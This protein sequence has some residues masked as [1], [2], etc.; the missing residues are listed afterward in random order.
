MKKIIFFLFIALLGKAQDIIQ[1]NNWQNKGNSWGINN[2]YIGTNDNR[3]FRVRTSGIERFVIDTTATAS[4][5]F[6]T[7]LFI[8]Q[9]A[10][11]NSLSPIKFSFR[12]WTFLNSYPAL[13]FGQHIENTTN[14]FAIADTTLT[15]V[16]GPQ[17]LYLGQGG[18]NGLQI[19]MLENNGNNGTTLAASGHYFFTSGVPSNTVPANLFIPLIVY[20]SLTY[21]L[22]GGIVPTAYL[23]EELAPNIKSTTPTTI[24]EWATQNFPKPIFDDGV[25]VTRMFGVQTNT[26]ISVAGRGIFGLVNTTPTATLDVRGN[27]IISSSLQVNGITNTDGF[28]AAGTGSVGS[29]FTATGAAVLTGGVTTPTVIGTTAAAGTL[30]LWGTNSATMGVISIGQGTAAGLISRGTTTLTGQANLSNT[31]NILGNTTLNT[32]QTNTLTGGNTGTVAVLTDVNLNYE[33]GFSQ[34]NPANNS[35]YGLTTVGQFNVN[36]GTKA[37]IKLPY[38]CTFIGYTYTSYN[39]TT[40]GSSETATLVLCKGGTATTTLSSAVSF[41]QSTATTYFLTDLAQSINYDANEDFSM[42]LKTPTFGTPPVATT[43]MLVALFVRRK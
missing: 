27:A 15:K 24:T 3:S 39:L 37:R 25:T 31:L 17:T 9:S 36:I 33:L 43:V 18:S 4:A 13:Y 10:G 35:T 32:N 16:N 1:L 42:T 22:G 11:V 41:T 8:D 34:Q 19:Q 38:N 20:P 23:V 5:K 7:S 2:A 40:A 26:D 21:S 30:T 29:T 12:P 28:T 6:N 14:F